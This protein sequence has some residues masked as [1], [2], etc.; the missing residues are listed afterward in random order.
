MLSLECHRVTD[1]RSRRCGTCD[2]PLV[3]RFSMHEVRLPL[4]HD[5]IHYFLRRRDETL[6]IVRVTISDSLRSHPV[7]IIACIPSE[8]HV[9]PRSERRVYSLLEQ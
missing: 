3:D 1:T 2:P 4:G 5:S 7:W 9:Q 8:H 6:L